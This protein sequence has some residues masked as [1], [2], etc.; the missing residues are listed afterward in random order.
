MEIINQQTPQQ[1]LI[2][3][4]RRLYKKNLITTLTGNISMLVEKNIYITPTSKDKANLIPEDIAILDIYGN[5]IKAK[6]GV[7][8]EKDIHVGIY[9]QR[10]DIKGIIHAHPFWSSLLCFTD[11]TLLTNVLEE[12]FYLLKKIEF[13]EYN[14]SG[15]FN[16]A[17]D[18]VDKSYNSDLIIL[19]NHGIFCLGTSLCDAL[20]KL[21]ILEKTV[22]YSFLVKFFKLNYFPLKK[23]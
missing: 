16:L 15:S 7:S 8:I 12:S 22:F 18:V 23:L 10:K 19:K 13:V 14:P 3:F 11:F 20:N 5:I 1:I 4:C 21:E 2:N 9:Y 6:A 17:K